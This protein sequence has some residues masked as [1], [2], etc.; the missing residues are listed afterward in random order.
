MALFR[1]VFMNICLWKNPESTC[2]RPK[3]YRLYHAELGSKRR[4][5]RRLK[6]SEGGIFINLAEKAG[7]FQILVEFLFLMVFE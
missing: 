1:F 2:Y 4:E 7:Q 3:M 6:K 5:N